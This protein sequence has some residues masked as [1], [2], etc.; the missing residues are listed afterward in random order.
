MTIL[1]LV[2]TLMMWALIAWCV[3]QAARNA[4]RTCS[5]RQRRGPGMDC[6]WRP[7]GAAAGSQL[8]FHSGAEAAVAAFPIH[9]TNGAMDMS[10]AANR[11]EVKS[12]DILVIGHQW[13]WEVQ[14][15]DGGPDQQFTTAN[16]IHI[17]AHRPVN[18]ELAIG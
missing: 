5:D 8:D 9:G 14:Y 13:W 17:P 12:P 16:E 15:L 7:G 10:H 2:V 1:F 18:I 6:H 11:G 3:H 4:R